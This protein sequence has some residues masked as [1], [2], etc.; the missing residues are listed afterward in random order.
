MK[1]SLVIS[2]DGFVLYPFLIIFSSIIILING[3]SV[4]IFQTNQELRN[5]SVL[6]EFSLLE[7]ETIKRVK[8]QFLTFNPKKFEFMIGEW[9][10]SVEFVDETAMIIYQGTKTIRASMFYDTV[11]KNVLDYHII[12]T[13]NSNS[14]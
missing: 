7:I 14:D 9:N 6:D 3:I 10:I 4:S 8:D 1:H 11:F 5:A 12:D 13:S 2:N